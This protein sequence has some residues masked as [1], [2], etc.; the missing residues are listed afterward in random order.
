MT[1]LLKRQK[2][3]NKTHQTH[4]LGKPLLA[5]GET[6]NIEVLEFFPFERDEDRDFLSGTLKIKLVDFGICVLGIYVTKKKNTWFFSLPGRTGTDHE[7]GQE[8][9]FPFV[10]FEDREKHKELIEAIRD[11]GRVF[12][13]AR[14]ADTS[15]PLSF[16]AKKE[17]KTGHSKTF[18]ANNEAVATKEAVSIAKPAVNPSIASKVWQDPPKR[19]QT[20]K[21]RFK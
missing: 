2:Q 13:E 16:P 6:M 7:T 21:Q 10:T 19:I 18:K 12:V 4:Q 1:N 15:K 14:L 5:E 3:T 8:I 20:A 17:T 9:R 11:Q